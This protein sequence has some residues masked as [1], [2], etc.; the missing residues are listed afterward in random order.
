MK[1]NTR[2][3]KQYFDGA[4]K[5]VKSTF[6]RNQYIPCALNNNSNSSRLKKNKRR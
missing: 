1:M 3:F 2:V 5:Q 6:G 4:E